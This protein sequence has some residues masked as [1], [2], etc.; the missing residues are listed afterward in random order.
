MDGGSS[1]HLSESKGIPPWFLHCFLKS[2]VAD[3]VLPPLKALTY[4]RGGG[5]TGGRRDDAVIDEF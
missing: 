1:R 3:E 2:R 5:R 4:F